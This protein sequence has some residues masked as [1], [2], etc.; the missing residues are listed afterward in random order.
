MIH[1]R[2]AAIS[3]GLAIASFTACGAAPATPPV[4]V[5]NA[6]AQS[7]PP[8]TGAP[9]AETFTGSVVETMNSGGYTYVRLQA[10]KKDVWVATSELAVKIGERLTVS[11]EALMQNFHS[12]TLGRDFPEIY[13]VTSVA[14]E[15]ETLAAPRG[16]AAASAMMASHE[17]AAGAAAT[18]VEPIPPAPGG[19]SIANVWAKRTSLAGTQVVVRAKVVKVNNDIMDRNWLHLQDGSGSATDGTN[20]LTITTAA[21]V[22]AGD[23]VTASGVLAVGKDFGSGYAYEAI[24]E[25]ATVTVI[26][27]AGG[28]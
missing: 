3:V 20:D 23:I 28:K 14:R 9:D 5:R 2:R 7:A 10:G 18:P 11:L 19:T 27:G 8:A 15:G 17:A 6:A 21:D 4:T 12:S 25:Q 26:R 22:K 16:Q 1:A 13:F 24:L